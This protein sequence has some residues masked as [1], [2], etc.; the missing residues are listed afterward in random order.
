VE[1]WRGGSEVHAVPEE[2][3]APELRRGQRFHQSGRRP[4]KRELGRCR[5]GALLMLVGHKRFEGLEAPA[6]DLRDLLAAKW[7]RIC[8]R[9]W[10]PLV[11]ERS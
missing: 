5:G 10:V 6:Q 4:K 8:T 11:W 2:P 7:K 3:H 1:A 9:L